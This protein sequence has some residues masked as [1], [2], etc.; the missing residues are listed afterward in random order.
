[1]SEENIHAEHRARM[2]EKYLQMRDAMPDH[3]ILELLLFN[4][5]PRRNTN[6]IAHALLNRFGSL[7]EVFRASIPQLT[8]V[9]GVGEKTAMFLKEIQYV[10]RRIETSKSNHQVLDTYEKI[11]KYLV[12]LFCTETNE[13]VYVV[14]LDAK[15]RLMSSRKLFEGTVTSASID[16]RK[17]A[18]YALSQGAAR[19]ILA[20]N[21]LSGSAEPSD[22][23][24]STTRFLRRSL[25]QIDL[26]LEEHFIIAGSSYCPLLDYM[27]NYRTD[28]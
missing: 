5:I 13:S 21:H 10:W 19:I 22:E 27:E 20:H 12:A 2:R 4:V 28:Y 3:E 6:P 9:E 18:S 14:L 8:S 1:M 7:D 25:R 26:I 16:A 24:I 11:A 15:A 17:I 23:D